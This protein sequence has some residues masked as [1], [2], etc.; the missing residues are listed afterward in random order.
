MADTNVINI[1]EQA[2]V[3]LYEE[4]DEW[5]HW[6][7][8]GSIPL[9]DPDPHECAALWLESPLVDAQPGRYM[10]TTTETVVYLTIDEGGTIQ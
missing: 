7:L 2:H 8:L 9:T 5:H 6:T 1:P 4:T 10:I 3:W